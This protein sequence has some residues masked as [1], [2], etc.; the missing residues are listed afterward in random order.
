MSCD[1]TF[2][3]FRSYR[4]MLLKWTFHGSADTVV[5]AVFA[6]RK[7]EIAARWVP[8]KQKL[9]HIPDALAAEADDIVSGL[10]EKAKAECW[11][12]DDFDD[13]KL[14]L[15]YSF[16]LDSGMRVEACRH[17]TVE[18]IAEQYSHAYLTRASWVDTLTEDVWHVFNG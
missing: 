12:L 8:V 16:R 11:G 4:T 10:V 13:A 7:G 9:P 14:S 17:E 2:N 3:D 18:D 5:L 1:C 6:L 15:H